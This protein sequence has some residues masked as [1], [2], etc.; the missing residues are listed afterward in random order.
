M[1]VA[2]V[3]VMYDVAE[4]RV[5]KVFRICKK[6]LFHY[7]NSIFRGEI[8]PSKLVKLR[9]ELLSVIDEQEDFVCFLKCKNAYVFD[10]EVIG[11]SDENGE[12]LL[13]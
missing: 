12:S 9:N 3:I 5:N 10:E 13:L 8:T 1:N 7:Q 2:Y 4:G 11:K 6:Y